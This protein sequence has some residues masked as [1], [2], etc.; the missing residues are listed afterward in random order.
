MRST[1]LEVDTELAG[2]RK[3]ALDELFDSTGPDGTRDRQLPAA[4]RGRRRGRNPQARADGTA[5]EA[6]A[7]DAAI[8][9]DTG[10][11]RRRAFDRTA[12]R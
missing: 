9:R 11:I 3:A 12:Y 6:I 2:A 5:I 7:R 8:N 10:S 1:T 4:P